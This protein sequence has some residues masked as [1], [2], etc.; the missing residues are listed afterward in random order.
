M[1]NKDM[2]QINKISVMAVK[3]LDEMFGTPS[4]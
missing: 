3:A 1:I 4:I 2:E